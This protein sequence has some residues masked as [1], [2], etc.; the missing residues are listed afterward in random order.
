MITIN[1]NLQEFD[2]DSF[3][4]MLEIMGEFQGAPRVAPQPSAALEPKRRGRPPGSALAAALAEQD[5]P[6]PTGLSEEDLDYSGQSW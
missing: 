2:P 4:L 1:I 5:V 3:R 6:A